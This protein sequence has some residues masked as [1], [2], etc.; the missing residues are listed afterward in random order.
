MGKLK[1]S[2]IVENVKDAAKEALVEEK[3]YDFTKTLKKMLTMGIETLVSTIVTFIT[4]Y[5]AKLNIKIPEEFQVELVLSG[6]LLCNSAI[7]GLR[8][9]WN[10]R[11]MGKE[12]KN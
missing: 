6:V 7:E 11:K 9:W 1:D 8:N 5:L 2:V 3:V 4:I 12:D 10:H